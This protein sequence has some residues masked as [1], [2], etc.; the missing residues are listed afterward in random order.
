MTNGR[1]RLRGAIHEQF[2]RLRLSGPGTALRKARRYVDYTR[3]VLPHLRAFRESDDRKPLARVARELRLV[4]AFWGCAP[5]HYFLYRLYENHFDL[6]D[7]DL[8]AWIPDW[9]WYHVF[10]QRV[11]DMAYVALEGDKNVTDVVLHAAGVPVVVPLWKVARGAVTDRGF[12]P[13]PRGEFERVV[14]GLR[15]DRVFGKPVAG[16]GGE[17][18]AIFRRRPDGS[19]RT[20]DDRLLCWDEVHRLADQTDWVFQEGLPQ[21]ESARRIHAASINT[22][23]PVTERL[24]GGEVRVVAVTLRM[25][26]GGG[27]TDNA[28]VGGISCGVD[29][30]T[31]RC[32]KWAQTD[33]TLG[34][35]RRTDRHPDSG[36]VFEGY[37]LPFRDEVLDA[38]RRG[39]SA[40]Y[41]M[42]IMSWD[43]ALTPRGPVVLEANAGL[44]L[45]HLQSASHRGLRRE[46]RI[47]PERAAEGIP[48]PPGLAGRP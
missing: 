10:I 4:Q 8:C 46:F 44:G 16:A 23:R 7:E 5:F 17:G 29:L 41:P 1:V 27:D 33:G 25:G 43:V 30:D 45:S 39:A 40:L 2:D 12:Q 21:H 24:P 13:M 36:V 35:I 28:H 11:N 38:L 48:L 47:G 9:Y 32:L 6:S 37:K 31:W 42:P 18:F 26:V 22:L 19:Y 3:D 14:A 20:D 34:A 15:C